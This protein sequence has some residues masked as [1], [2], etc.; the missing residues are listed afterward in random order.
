MLDGKLKWSSGSATADTNLYR[1]SADTLKT[2]D[3]FVIEGNLTVNGTTTTVNSTV[4]TVDDKNIELASSGSPSDV[5]ADGG[6]I[7]LRGTTDKT[8]NWIDSTDSWT[9]SEN[10]D[11]A[12]GKTY[13]INGTNV[14]SSNTLGSGIIYSSL[15]TLGTVSSLQATSPNFTGTAVFSGGN[16][17][18]D[19]FGNVGIVGRLDIAETREVV[20]DAAASSNTFTCDY[21]TGAIFYGTGSLTAN[22]T[23]NIT[24][25]PT[26]NG[27][28]MTVSLFVTQGATGYIPT[29]LNI[30]GSSATIKWVGG[31]AP[32]P[33]SSNGKIDIFNFTL[34]RRSSTWTVLANANLNY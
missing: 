15:T 1:A 34:I 2:D 29:T 13:K 12:S 27:K 22:F 8:F 33:T 16:F 14:L 6:G 20:N 18:L 9:S 4:L 24:N 30:N 5:A 10:L 28:A 7:T 25:A 19:M 32:T 31:S 11:V 23:V 26:D 21:S 17:T 3:N